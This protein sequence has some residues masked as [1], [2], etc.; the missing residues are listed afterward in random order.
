MKQFKKEGNVNFVWDK[1]EIVFNSNFKYDWSNLVNFGMKNQCRFHTMG[2]FK[3]YF[4][5]FHLNPVKVGDREW[6]KDNGGAEV[7]F[8]IPKGEMKEKF[9]AA[10]KKDIQENFLNVK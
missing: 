1:D 8:R 7:S 5:I 10:W 9:L 6:I 3:Y 2:I 4:R